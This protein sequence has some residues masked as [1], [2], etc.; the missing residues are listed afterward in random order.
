MAGAEKIISAPAYRHV[1]LAQGSLS[2]PLPWLLPSKP[3]CHYPRDYFS[4]KMASNPQISLTELKELLGTH[5]CALCF[6]MLLSYADL[7]FK[8]VAA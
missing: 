5:S 6:Y 4:A 2:S 8:D 3:F 1:C 7:S